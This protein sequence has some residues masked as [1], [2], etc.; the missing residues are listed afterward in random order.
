MSASIDRLTELIKEAEGRALSSNELLDRY[1]QLV[2]AEKR[3]QLLAWLGFYEQERSLVMAMAADQDLSVEALIRQAIRHYQL[4]KYPP[5][6]FPG[7]P[8]HVPC[9]CPD[10]SD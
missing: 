5:P 6:P 10:L 1:D 3:T 9:G 8:D 2:G 7:H 4:L